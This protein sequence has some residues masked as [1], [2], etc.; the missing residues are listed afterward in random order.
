MPRFAANISTMFTEHTLIDRIKAA[1]D[2]LKHEDRWADLVAKA[3]NAK[4]V[5]KKRRPRP[6]AKS[7]KKEATSEA[8][9]PEAPVKAN[10]HAAGQQMPQT[11]SRAATP[12][13]ESR[14]EP[15]EESTN[16]KAG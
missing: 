15:V 7:S 4:S 16:A 11:T 2:A 9:G 1:A 6:A 14:P 5:K 3:P 12:P 13:V 10:G 8:T